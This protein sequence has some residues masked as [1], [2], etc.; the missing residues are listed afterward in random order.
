MKPASYWIEKYN[1]LPHPEG[2]HY[3]ETYRSAES[4][5]GSALPARFENGSRAFSTGIYFLLEQNQFSAFHRIKSDEMWH[6]YAGE[7]L[8]IFVI[9]PET[10]QL[11]VIKLGANPENGETFQAVVP[12]GTWFASRPAKDSSYALVGC[13]VSPGFDFADFE[14]ANKNDLIQLFP[15]HESLIRELA[16]S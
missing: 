9:Y 4:V 8:D 1:L 7:A 14:M 12:A 5:A 6:F 11:E 3:I 15:K 16:I 13:T 2:G 10:S